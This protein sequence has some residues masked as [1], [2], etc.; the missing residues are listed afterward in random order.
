MSS[1]DKLQLSITFKYHG[2]RMV[3]D[4]VPG[5]KEAVAAE[6]WRMMAEF[7][8][9]ILQRGA[10]FAQLKALNLSPGH[11]KVLMALDPGMS[12]PMG[13]IADV[14]GCDPSMATWL[15]DRLEEQGIV[16]R[17]TLASDR[18]VKAVTL[19]AKGER[20]KDGLR[21]RLYEPP[22]ELLEV[23]KATLVALRRELAKL[24]RPSRGVLR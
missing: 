9:R 23:D 3:R 4:P 22:D 21:S 20:T 18:R 2:D 16:E 7:S 14:V 19:T 12:L 15:V 24:P 8:M 1:I 10:A 17:Q 13:A 5:T 6:V 11:L